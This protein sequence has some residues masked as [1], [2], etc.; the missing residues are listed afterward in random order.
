MRI[1]KWKD[2]CPKPGA[3]YR[4]HKAQIPARRPFPYH[5]HDFGEFFWTLE[6][7]GTHELNGQS[8]PTHRGCAVFMRPQD[9]HGFRPAT[10]QTIVQYNLVIPTEKLDQFRVR[11]FRENAV[12][13]WHDGPDPHA[14]TLSNTQLRRLS[15]AGDELIH[16]SSQSL[17]IDQFLLNLF[18]DL[19]EEMNAP[20]HPDMPE[21]LARACLRANQPEVIRGGCEAFVKLAGHSP[22]HVSRVFHKHMGK[23]LIQYL[24]ELR[25]TYAEREL[26][27][28]STPVIEIAHDCGFSSLGHFYKLF[29]QRYGCPPRQYRLRHSVYRGYG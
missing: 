22:E 23:T 3:V 13:F 18:C 7:H 15:R 2:V 29:S 8:T 25:L 12:F 21:W 24:T 27:S 6:G 26:V 19:S 20:A 1:F 16:R 10:G 4:L 28:N 14:V 17:A 5:G 11:Y 9:R